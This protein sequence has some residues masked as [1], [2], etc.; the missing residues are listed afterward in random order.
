MLSATLSKISRIDFIR[1]KNIGM[2]VSSL[3]LA[4]SVLFF[5][6]KGFNFGI[7][8]KGGYLF[9]I[10]TPTPADHGDIRKRLNALN[11][12]DVKVQGFGSNRDV[13]IRIEASEQ[14]DASPHNAL[15]KIK[16]TLGKDVDY[17]RVETVGAKVSAD[18]IENGL[19][20]A[21][22][23]L[24]GILLYIWFRFEW[25]FG[26]CAILG[27]VH[28]C[29][30][31]VGF[32]SL[33]ELEFNETAIIVFLTV[34]GYSI[35]DTVVIYDRIRDN[36]RKYKKKPREE[37]I[38]D[39]LNETLTRTILTSLTTLLALGCLYLFGGNVIASFSLPILVG[40]VVGTYSSLF[41][42]PYLLL[43]FPDSRNRKE[44][45]EQDVVV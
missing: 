20:A 3:L 34:L 22:F 10:R 37:I 11:L 1:F 19:L 27:L 17:R 26:L 41:F 15:D 35:N 12:G 18:L 24:I 23:A 32:Y 2:I 38:N 21:G 14:G 16:S 36:L 7:D 29:L 4:G 5:V 25:E 8:F 28:D 40:I 43:I 44:A 31:I 30:A 6:T 9:E 42:V 33:F 13:I 45:E 39:S